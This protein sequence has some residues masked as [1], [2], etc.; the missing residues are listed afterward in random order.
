MFV[1]EWSFR[2]T[3]LWNINKRWKKR[4]KKSENTDENGAS[5]INKAMLWIQDQDKKEKHMIILCNRRTNMYK[6][7]YAC[8]FI[9]ISFSHLLVFGFK[10]LWDD[11][12]FRV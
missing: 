3:G 4:L 6:C 11:C 1:L 12:A 9:L 5:E 2:A 8:V 10:P 7:M